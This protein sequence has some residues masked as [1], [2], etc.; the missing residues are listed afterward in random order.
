MT[1]TTTMF[2]LPDQMVR[3][4]H[5]FID[6][7]HVYTSDE[8]HGLYVADKDPLRAFAAVVPSLLKLMALNGTPP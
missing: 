6:G 2:S 8:V 1:T 5:R 7:N 4:Q 3:V